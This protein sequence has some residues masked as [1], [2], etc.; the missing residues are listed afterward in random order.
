MNR[1]DERSFVEAHRTLVLGLVKK[2]RHQYGIVGQDEDLEAAGFRG[3]VEAHHRYDPA[4][5]TQLSTFAYYRVRGAILDEVRRMAHLPRRLHARLKAAQVADG[6]AEDIAERRKQ[7]GGTSAADAQRD[8][9][10][11][12]K[13]FASSFATDAV[14]TGD[15]PTDDGSPEEQLLRQERRA[16]L[17]ERIDA[18]PSRERTLIRGVYFEDREMQAVAAD[19]GVSKSWASRLHA[20]ALSLLRDAYEA[21]PTAAAHPTADVEARSPPKPKAESPV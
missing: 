2:V 20:R 12:A 15:E 17:I 16:L 10:E 19:L 3:L 14:A 6:F 13:L 4:R 8:L 18:L 9:R 1:G 21:Q 11:Y 7:S 5:G